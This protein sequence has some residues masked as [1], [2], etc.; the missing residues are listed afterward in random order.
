V[1]KVV[2]CP[3]CGFEGEFKILK[4]W[5]FRFYNVKKLQCPKCMGILNHYY[6]ASPRGEVSEFVIRVSPRVR[7]S[8]K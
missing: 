4:T 3:Y 7:K 6:G 5:K 1:E 2:K 8:I